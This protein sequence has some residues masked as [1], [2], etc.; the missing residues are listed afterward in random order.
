[1]VRTGKTKAPAVTRIAGLKKK[2][3]EY[4]AAVARYPTVPAET[5]RSSTYFHDRLEGAVLCVPPCG[6]RVIGS[7]V[8]QDP[9]RIEFCSAHAATPDLYGALDRLITLCINRGFTVDELAEAG[10]ARVRAR[11][12]GR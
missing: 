12:E 5:L 11:G 6:C 4:V 2:L 3:A 9:V 10:T 8:C 1:M 7:G